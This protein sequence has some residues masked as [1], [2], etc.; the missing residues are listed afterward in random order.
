M[1]VT[2]FNQSEC[3]ISLAW[4]SSEIHN[5]RS[6][7]RPKGG[8]GVVPYIGYVGMRSAKGYG[9]FS[10]FGLNSTILV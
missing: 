5:L 7:F 10:R 1:C 4:V 3:V 6:V 2:R 9:F 8:G